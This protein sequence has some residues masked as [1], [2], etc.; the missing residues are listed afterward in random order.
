M[1]AS[2]DE[3]IQVTSRQWGVYTQLEY[4]A[5]GCKH[6]L[7]NGKAP[8]EIKFQRLQIGRSLLCDSSMRKTSGVWA[9]K[10]PSRLLKISS[11]SSESAVLLSNCTGKPELAS[12]PRHGS[13]LF[14]MSCNSM[15]S[16]SSSGT[17][18]WSLSSDGT[19]LKLMVW[20]SHRPV[21]SSRRCLLYFR[22]EYGWLA[23]ECSITSLNVPFVWHNTHEYSDIS[24]LQ[25]IDR[26]INTLIISFES[27]VITLCY[28]LNSI[29]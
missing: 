18:T 23:T 14:A 2:K 15:S 19:M 22:V 8:A 6:I 20:R 7:F 10:F 13:E 5:P 29:A 24:D 4:E 3:D 28:I 21:E 16:V 12:F 17:M 11:S 9:I 1:A 26:F 25:R 27:N